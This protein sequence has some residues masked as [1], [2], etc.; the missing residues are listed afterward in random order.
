MC[1]VHCL[2]YV[3]HC[4]AVTSVEVGGLGGLD[5]FLVKTGSQRA[6]EVHG[7]TGKFILSLNTNVFRLNV[8]IFL[9][10]FVCFP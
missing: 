3:A 9:P 6:R 2:V 4:T 7:S 5:R 10:I 8:K 1:I